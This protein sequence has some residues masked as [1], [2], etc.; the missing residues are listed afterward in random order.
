MDCQSKEPCGIIPRL[1][2]RFHRKMPEI[3]IRGETMR[4][5]KSFIILVILMTLAGSAAA[6]PWSWVWYPGEW[7]K[8][9]GKYFGRL[10]FDVDADVATAYAFF[11]GDNFLTLYLNG[12]IV[13]RSGDWYTLKPVTKKTLLPLLKKGKN[14]LAVYVQN[15][16]Y[17]GGFA[18][19]GMVLLSSGKRILL[20]SNKSWKCWNQPVEEWESVDFDDSK[21]VATEEIGT[22]PA[23]V[24]G[25]PTMPPSRFS[26]GTL[27][28]GN[29]ESEKAFG[30][31][32]DGKKIESELRFADRSSMKVIGRAGAA[33]ETFKVK[34]AQ[35][36]YLV[37]GRLVPPGT[38]LNAKVA[39]DGVD[40]GEWK[41]PLSTGGDFTVK[42]YFVVPYETTAGKGEVTVTITPESPEKF[43]SFGY[44]LMQTFEWFMFDEDA[45]GTLDDQALMKKVNA[46]PNDA[47]SAFMLGFVVEGSRNWQW[48][49]NLYRKCAE[50]AKGSDLGDSAYRNS[51][52]CDAML[53]LRTAKPDAGMYCRTAMFLKANQFYAEASDAFRSSI[54]IKPTADAYDQLG[55]AM[56]FGGRPIADCIAVWKEGL[57]KFP[58]K[59]TNVWTS[60]ITLSPS[61]EQREYVDAQKKQ[62]DIMD[63]MIYLSSRGRMKLDSKTIVDPP[64]V[65]ELFGEG[66]LDTYITIAGGAGGGSTLGPDVTY[67]HS[68]WSGFGFVTVW[69]VA[70]HEWIHQFECGLGASRNGTGW[71][72]CHGSTHFGYRP[73]WWNWY[74]AA[75]RYYVRPGQYERVCLSDH[76]NVPYADKWLVKGPFES[77]D[78]APKWICYPGKRDAA[79]FAWATRKTFEL[80]SLPKKAVISATGDDYSV[81][82]INGSF[83]RKHGSWMSAP[84]DDIL[85]YLKKGKNVI[86]LAGLNTAYGGAVIAYATIEFADGKNADVATDE[87]WVT[88]EIGE[89]EFN[90]LVEGQPFPE[91]SK[92]DFDDGAWKTPEVVGRYPCGPWNVIQMDL[93]NRLIS[94]DFVGAEK[95]APSTKD[96]W[97]PAALQQ[98]AFKLSEIAP[99][100]YE[101]YQTMTYA[102]T[103]V[104]S[105]VD[106]RANML[107]GASRRT[108]IKLNGEE[109]C[110]HMGNGFPTLPEVFPVVLRK[111]WNRLLVRSEDVGQQSVFYLKIFTSDGEAIKGLKYSNEKPPASQL[112]VDQHII[113]TFSASRPMY[114]K[115]SD[116]S[117][118]P[119]TLTPRL[120]GDDL[121]KYMGYGSGVAISGGDNFLFVRVDSAK[122]IPGYSA[123]PKYPGGEKEVNNA[124]TWDFEPLAVVRYMRGGKPKDLIF[125][126]PDAEELIFQTGLLK[127]AKGATRPEERILGWVFEG[128]RLCVVAETELGDLP[129]RTMDLLTL[130]GGK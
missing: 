90:K 52:L 33:G 106:I 100:K 26:L 39:I 68:G 29:A 9:P 130:D 44:E 112:V 97:K 84:S 37:L 24:W 48:A 75:M 105:P 114:Y 89:E 45:T 64:P 23:G 115:W 19:K 55:E 65:Q 18:L 20:N 110:A 96:G 14:V 11:T 79:N 92:I 4:L 42:S 27:N 43:V 72:G 85:K 86:S 1:W 51:K 31:Q 30:Y 62:M 82:Y 25:A 61:E 22:P 28:V 91:W 80:A 74:R 109:V 111:G 49:G 56:L 95:N 123:L 104:F 40:L 125:I 13:G 81:L 32:G 98:K 3:A 38:N 108:F 102:F 58:P 87:T 118:D 70:W 119:Y 124:L 88:R 121:A 21:W 54:S 83:V 77:P 113:P 93:P 73:P 116:V 7:Q 107:L 71:G 94:T 41:A 6:D 35:I 36:G 69:D 126:K 16:D 78:A 47:A 53:K 10:T 122:A 128:G 34:P 67:G 50:L 117:E 76:W 59:D 57:A 63:D 103:Y 46:N 8:P 15:D 60:I 120:T 99:S 101:A 12:Q 17:E 127:T 2:N 5:N 129:E 66:E